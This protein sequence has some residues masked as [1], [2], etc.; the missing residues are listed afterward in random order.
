MFCNVYS[1]HCDFSKRM[2]PDAC[3][4]SKVLMLVSPRCNSELVAKYA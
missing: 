3:S 1:Y 2:V 4:K